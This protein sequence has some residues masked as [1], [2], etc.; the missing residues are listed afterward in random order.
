MINELDN[1]FSVTK[2]TEFTDEEIFEY[3]VNFNTKD[4]TSIE[5]ILNPREYLPK[6]VIGGKGCGKTHIL[7]YFSF[8][9]QKIRHRN[10]VGSLL[11]NDKYIGLYSV[12][13]GLN[14]SRFSGKGI[15]ED[16]WLSAFE[17]YFEL[18][19]CDGLL[20][21]A[22]EILAALEITQEQEAKLTSEVL[23]IFNNSNDLAGI[24]SLSALIDYLVELRRKIDTQVLNAAFTRKLD[25][26]DVKVHFSP[27]DL[28]FGIPN[29]M[30]RTIEALKD[31]KFIFI[32]DEYEKLFEWQKKFV[33]TL[34]WDK[35]PP[36]TFWIGA[37]RYGYTT[38]K[39]KSGQEMK[40]GS[41]FSDVELDL[42][43]RSNEEIYRQFAEQLYTNRLLK[44]YE[45]KG[46]K[47]KAH[48]VR[49]SFCE[50]FE[51]FEESKIIEEVKRKG[52]KK[53]YKHIKELRKKLMEGIKAS[54]AMDIRTE[55]DVQKV[56][57]CV[58]SKT[59]NNPLVQKYKAFHFYKLW[60]DSKKE[61]RYVD[62]LHT[63][64]D[65]FNKFLASQKSY[66][67]EIID[68]RKQDFIAQMT[69]ENKLKNIEYAGISEF[70]R[71]SQ[72]NTRS[73]I[74][75]LK[76]AVEFAKIKG[77]RPL[78][79]GGKISLDSQYLAVHDTARWFYEDA[80]LVGEEGRNVYVA[81]KKLTDYFIIERFCDKPVET[82][83]SCFY[84]KMEHLSQKTIDCLQLM[85][86]HSILIADPGGRTEKNSGRK[87][88]LFQINK[89]LAPLWNLPTVVR[90]TLYINSELAEAIFN[91][92]TG[93]NFEQ[94][95]TKRRNQLNAPD[96]I[97]NR[98]DASP[99]TLFN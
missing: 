59:D 65:E 75:I 51:P 43:I 27:G 73:F 21:T 61:S 11:A 49:K 99:T 25:Y 88:Q 79:E 83:V 24:S 34:V 37:R 87:E 94:L 39:T 60:Y 12:F 20:H 17:Y 18:Y 30:S 29:C 52:T 33:N 10:D 7:R 42:I 93:N 23:S 19:V 3:W 38:R 64:E 78:E 74:L 4:E 54:V 26:N 40:P 90:G 84:V 53:E 92:E 71:L 2:A 22:G 89:M 95:F 28:L 15:G 5:T 70:I 31:V 47:A 63:I 36:V 97:K 77:E 76:K 72:G 46:L 6:Y 91:C 57:E 48:D 16:E 1:P 13:H 44:Y 98:K 81:L 86:M 9:L 66:Y 41:E 32:F 14:S 85:Q 69:K 35:K 58:E 56:V 96:F 67:D 50:R 62:I 8:P 68:K 55:D 80:E 82:T 45:S